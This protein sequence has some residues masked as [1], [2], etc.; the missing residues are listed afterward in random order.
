MKRVLFMLIM[1]VSLSFLI[2]ISSGEAKDSNSVV[3]KIKIDNMFNVDKVTGESE[4]FKK[5]ITND[6]PKEKKE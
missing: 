4:I 5:S 1:I 2:T 3:E 6:T